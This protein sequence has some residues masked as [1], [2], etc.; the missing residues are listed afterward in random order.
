MA[1][2]DLVKFQNLKLEIKYLVN[3][4]KDFI[5]KKVRTITTYW[6]DTDYSKQISNR[7]LT[8]FSS[9]FSFVSS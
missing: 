7:E 1:H 8:F 2:F 3:L 5:L 4:E 6:G 9:L